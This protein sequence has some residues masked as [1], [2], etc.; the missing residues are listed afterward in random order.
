MTMVLFHN[1][2]QYCATRFRVGQLTTYNPCRG[3]I[4]IYRA[5]GQRWDKV[6]RWDSVL[7]E[8]RDMTGNVFKV[9]DQAYEE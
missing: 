7:C 4:D 8:Y 9:E 5:N 2:T 6:A 1:K 3:A